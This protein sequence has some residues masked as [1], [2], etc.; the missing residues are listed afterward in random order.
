MTK[1][2]I[3]AAKTAGLRESPWGVLSPMDGQLG[4]SSPGH[5]GFSRS[6]PDLPACPW[7]LALWV[8]CRK[9]LALSST[10]LFAGV[11]WR[12]V[13]WI[14]ET[15]KERGS[16]SWLRS[17][18]PSRDQLRPGEWQPYYE[19]PP[20]KRIWIL[21]SKTNFQI[22]SRRAHRNEACSTELTRLPSNWWQ[23]TETQGSLMRTDEDILSGDNSKCKTVKPQPPLLVAVRFV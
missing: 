6:N 17:L 11:Q 5:T 7:S 10:C 9:Q 23:E 12:F 18:S 4:S 22:R 14:F 1:W 8:Y 21:N 2:V 3:W 15:H 16:F 20:G 13:C 19:Q